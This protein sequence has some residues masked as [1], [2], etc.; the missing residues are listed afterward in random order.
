MQ[1]KACPALTYEHV[2]D[3][4]KLRQKTQMIWDRQHNWSETDPDLAQQAL[5]IPMLQAEHQ[6]TSLEHRDSDTHV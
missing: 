4:S 2:T 1:Y 3:T 6:Q 5:I